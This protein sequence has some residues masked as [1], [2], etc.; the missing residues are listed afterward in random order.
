MGEGQAL[1]CHSRFDSS[2]FPT[3]SSFKPMNPTRYLDEITTDDQIKLE[4]DQVYSPTYNLKLDGYHIMHDTVKDRPCIIWAH[5][6]GGDKA[7]DQPVSSVKWFVR[8]G[9]VGVSINYRNENGEDLNEEDQKLGLSDFLAAVR[10][11]RLHAV[12]LGVNPDLIFIGG[13]SAGSMLSIEASISANNL[14]DPYFADDTKVNVDNPGVG[15]YVKASS[16][17]TGCASGH[18]E[19][20]IDGADAPNY[21]YAGTH[22]DKFPIAKVQKCFDL[23]VAAGIPCTITEYDAP[24]KIGHFDEIMGD[25]TTKFYALLGL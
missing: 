15:S 7:S 18:I 1:V 25:I 5:A 23:M 12:Q 10:W 19:P 20:F 14:S 6:G 17:V 2:S 11:V 22:D 9:Y 4:A 16:T 21:F 24:H 13:N 3:S 8:R